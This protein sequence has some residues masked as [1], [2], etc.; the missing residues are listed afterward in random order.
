VKAAG[1]ASRKTEVGTPP[2]YDKVGDAEYAR[3]WNNVFG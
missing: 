1:E 3:I 2:G